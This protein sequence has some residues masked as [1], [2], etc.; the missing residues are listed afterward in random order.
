M[1]ALASIRERLR[2]VPDPLGLLEGIFAFAPFG[3]QIYE[4]NG[5]SLLV[6]DAFRRMFG[7][8]PPPDYNVLNDEIAARKGVLGLIRRAFRGETV[9]IP[10]IWYDPRELSQVTIREGRRAAIDATFFPIVDAAGDVS[11]VA[12]VFKDLTDEMAATERLSF[13]AEAGTLLASSLDYESTLGNVLALALPRLGDFGFFDVVEGEERVRRV[14]GAH[15]DPGLQ[16]V[17]SATQWR[18]SPRTDINLC[19]LSTGR[20]ALHPDTDDRWLEAIAEGP[21]HL[22]FMRGLGFRSMLTVPLV[23]HQR[24]LG[25]LT[26]FRRRTNAAHSAADVPLA[27]E[28]AVRAASAVENARLYR[29]LKASEARAQSAV[30]AANEAHRRKDEFLAVLGHELRNPLAPILSAV[31][32]LQMKSG[33]Q[34]GAEVVVI[35]RQARH[36]ARLVD[37]LLDVSRITQGRIELRPEPVA[38]GEVL[39]EVLAASRAA[40]ESRG[41]QATLNVASGDL[42]VEADRVR[43]AQVVLNI[44]GNAVRYTPVGGRIELQADAR[45]GE[46]CISVRDTGTGITPELLPRVFAPFVQGERTLER[47]AGGVG[48]GLA[49]VRSLVELHGGKVSA[50]SGGPGQGTEVLVRLPRRFKGGAKPG[51]PRS[52]PEAAAAPRRRVLVVD[53]NRDAADLLGHAL[54]LAGHEVRIAEDGPS[55]LEACSELDPELAILDIGLPGM[56]GYE[57]AS[58]LRAARG[59]GLRLVA[60]SGFGQESD[61]RRSREAGFEEH[62]VKPVNI[63]RVY[64]IVAGDLA[65]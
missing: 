37:D 23:Y 16:A 55:A 25:A 27:E 60:L 9:Y 30:E 12:I 46:V 31:E 6:N 18:R 56:D 20:P 61:K 43:L 15:E 40:I 59:A 53:D 38:V 8:E 2:E 14:A 13:L 45:D 50:H 33:G 47:S 39:E 10:P 1:D 49:I 32:L 52:V 19:A 22:A 41:L 29:D 58:R 63:D 24:C 28:L 4:A 48:L 26:L 34:A 3:L 62:L 65:R 7:S 51:P 35:E 64:A 11:H 17:L 5:R 21:E 42:V 54:Q 57:L 44:L 36:I